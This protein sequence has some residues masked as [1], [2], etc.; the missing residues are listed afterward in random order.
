MP[1]AVS[2][3]PFHGSQNDSH[4]DN[5]HPHF[6]LRMPSGRRMSVRILSRMRLFAAGRKNKRG[7]R[8]K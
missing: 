8:K 3:S 4:G 6:L 1:Q 7:F 5:F 2:H